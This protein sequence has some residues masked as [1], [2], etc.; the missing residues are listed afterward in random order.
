MLAL[1]Y[2]HPVRTWAPCGMDPEKLR[3]ERR[4]HPESKWREGTRPDGK[5]CYLSTV[6]QRSSRE[7][8]GTI[9]HWR[10]FSKWAVP[11]VSMRELNFGLRALTPSLYLTGADAFAAARRYI[12]DDGSHPNAAAHVVLARIVLYALTQ[13]HRRLASEGCPEASLDADTSRGSGLAY[14]SCHFAD[15]LQALDVRFLG[16]GWRYVVEAKH[17]QPSAKGKPGFVTTVKS[18][19]MLIGIRLPPAALHRTGSAAAKPLDGG[20]SRTNTSS[21]SVSGIACQ[22][23]LRAPGIEE[24]RSG[25]DAADVAK[26][27]SALNRQE[28]RTSRASSPALLLHLGYL[29]S[30]EHMG[31]A[32]VTCVSGC[33]C[34]ALLL[35][36]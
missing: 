17:G 4:L 34:D 2:Q 23:A 16:S 30:Y 29:Q 26:D 31:S 33:E 10:V 28:G 25:D 27:R 5:P 15:T 22:A 1:D 14:A 19:A 20:A 12:V 24:T 8:P 7:R 11:V 21:T 36:G 13:A 35:E 18:S 32:R 6:F 9:K 3:R